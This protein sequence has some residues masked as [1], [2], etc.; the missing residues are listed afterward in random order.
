MLIFKWR[1][2]WSR[3]L[4]LSKVDMLALVD[5]KRLSSDNYG[6][7]IES[8]RNKIPYC[9]RYILSVK[10]LTACNPSIHNAG[11]NLAAP[12]RKL[13][14]KKYTE[15]FLTTKIELAHCYKF[16]NEKIFFTK[17]HQ[18]FLKKSNGMK[19]QELQGN[20]NNSLFLSVLY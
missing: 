10:N 19:R 12:C 13:E 9:T 15:I 16:A 5:L 4:V 7:H 2:F 6:F 3:F 1:N 11:L 8:G 20:Y 18:F 17:I 14:Y